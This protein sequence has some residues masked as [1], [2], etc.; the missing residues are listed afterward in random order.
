MLRSQDT[1]MSLMS[2][3]MG[4]LY[5]HI[6]HIS[7]KLGITKNQPLQECLLPVGHGHE[8]IFRT[9][10]FGNW[11]HPPHDFNIQSEHPSHA[12]SGLPYVVLD[13]HSVSWGRM[14]IVQTFINGEKYEELHLKISPKKDAIGGLEDSKLDLCVSV[15]H[16]STRHETLNLS[17]IFGKSF[18]PN[19]VQD[20]SWHVDQLNHGEPSNLPNPTVP[21]PSSPG[22]R[23]F[24]SSMLTMGNIQ[25][26]GNVVPCRISSSWST[27]STTLM[28]SSQ[29]RNHIHKSEL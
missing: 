19:L 18:H 10:Q 12:P 25:S 24:M 16:Y 28:L 9:H 22:F 4:S 20:H 29:W 7:Q 3:R 17:S 27:S 1:K 23:A 5:G 11:D 15:F 26:H 2:P 6:S 13:L 21:A 14:E 8:L